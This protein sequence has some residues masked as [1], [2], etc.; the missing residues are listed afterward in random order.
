L[1]D[2]QSRLSSAIVLVVAALVALLK[3][4][5]CNALNDKPIDH[6]SLQQIEDCQN[7]IDNVQVFCSRI[8]SITPEIKLC[9]LQAS[10]HGG[11]RASVIS[12]DSRVNLIG[13]MEIL[14]ASGPLGLKLWSFDGGVAR[15]FLISA[16]SD[17]KAREYDWISRTTIL[18]FSS[19]MTERLAIELSS[20]QART[21]S[22][23]FRE[24]EIARA[25]WHGE[26]QGR[27]ILVLH[28][29]GIADEAIA[30]LQFP[31]PE[32]RVPELVVSSIAKSATSP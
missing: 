1:L 14:N 18:E 15:S 16:P 8:S 31:W 3:L 27:M 19:E 12:S 5:G 30:A 24:Q 4:A 28:E 11:I 21:V 22:L 25:D 9:G 29:S 20:N 23:E 7:V 26:F 32:Q 17:V 2:L 10:S 13:I 6:P